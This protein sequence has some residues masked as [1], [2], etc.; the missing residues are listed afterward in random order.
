MDAQL[1][2]RKLIEA[3]EFVPFHD[4]LPLGGPIQAPSGVMYASPNNLNVGI[5]LDFDVQVSTDRSRIGA[6]IDCIATDLT[7]NTESFDLVFSAL[8]N[9]VP[10]EQFRLSNTGTV[11]SSSGTVAHVDDMPAAINAALAPSGVITQAMNAAI[12]AF[13]Q[14]FGDFNNALVISALATID[15]GTF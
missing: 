1:K 10:V 4:L 3:R 12:A 15:G 7:P 8:V 2:P 5:G 14:Q 9:G 11:T 13:A 6:T